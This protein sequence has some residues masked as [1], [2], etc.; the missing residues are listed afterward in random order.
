MGRAE[1]RDNLYGNQHPFGEDEIAY[2]VDN[3]EA[4]TDQL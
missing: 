1:V 3:C 2:I 4:V